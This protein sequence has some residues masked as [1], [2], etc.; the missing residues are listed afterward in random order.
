MGDSEIPHIIEF[1][2][3]E[4]KDTVSRKITIEIPPSIFHMT[5]AIKMT[6]N[7]KCF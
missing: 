7:S 2:C 1:K 6:S 4:G 5:E 3:G